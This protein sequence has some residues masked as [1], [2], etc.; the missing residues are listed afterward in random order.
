MEIWTI[1]SRKR[2]G[3][4]LHYLVDEKANLET[5][6]W[7]PSIHP[8]IHSL[9]LFQKPNNIHINND[10][11]DAKTNPLKMLWHLPFYSFWINMSQCF[12][13]PIGGWWFRVTSSCCNPR[14]FFE[15]GVVLVS[16]QNDHKSCMILTWY[17]NLLLFIWLIFK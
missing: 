3:S 15:A 4:N 10:K 11:V 6:T 17:N 1:A 13:T 14:K 7:F 9:S 12:T 16:A 8:S 5:G 2:A